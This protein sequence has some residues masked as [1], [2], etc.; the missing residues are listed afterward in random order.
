MTSD[1]GFACGTAAESMR[2]GEPFRIT[3]VDGDVFSGQ[4]LACHA[5]EFS[6]DASSHGGAFLRVSVEEWGGQTHAWCWLGAY[7]Q[8]AQELAALQARWD[9]MLERLFVVNSEAA[10]RGGV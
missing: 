3:S 8:N 10:A 7:D 6:G 4:A 9:T 2:E 1:E 5:R